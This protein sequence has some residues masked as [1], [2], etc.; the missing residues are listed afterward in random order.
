[1]LENAFSFVNMK[2]FSYAP[3]F[4]CHIL[5][6]SREQSQKG[7]DSTGAIASQHSAMRS[8]P[9]P[10]PPACFR[11]GLSTAFTHEK[12][13]ISIMTFESI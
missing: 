1:M 10:Q 12:G 3:V 9:G 13:K 7:S 11:K 8:N 4:I 6:A 2:A 5:S